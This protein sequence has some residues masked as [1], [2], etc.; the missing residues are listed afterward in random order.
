MK[1]ETR[2]PFFNWKYDICSAKLKMNKRNKTEH[3]KKICVSHREAVWI[4]P[5]FLRWCV[6][7][8]NPKQDTLKPFLLASLCHRGV[9]SQIAI[10]ISS[11]KPNLFI[12]F[13]LLQNHRFMSPIPQLQAKTLY[14]NSNIACWNQQSI[15]LTLALE[16]EPCTFYICRSSISFWLN[17]T[18]DFD[19]IT[20][21]T[22]IEPLSLKYLQSINRI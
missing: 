7:V 13:W 18:G 17:F 1:G 12:Y 4:T 5:V 19:E 22:I 2:V 16:N 20:F 21:C 9:S 15:L 14:S 11:T 6:W 8:G 3:T 10:L